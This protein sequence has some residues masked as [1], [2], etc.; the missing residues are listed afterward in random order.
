MKLPQ[1]TARVR[2]R[3]GLPRRCRESVGPGLLFAAALLAA[4][5]HAQPEPPI[6]DQADTEL[7]EQPPDQANVP[8]E[9]A[10][11]IQAGGAAGG[12][13]QTPPGAGMFDPDREYVGD[14]LSLNFQEIDTRAVLQLLAD[15]SRLNIVVSD[16]VQG[17]VTLRLQD[18]P[19]DQAL[20]IVLTTNG[21]DMRQNGNVIIVAPAEEIA[22]HDRSKTSSRCVRS[23][24]RSTTPAPMNSRR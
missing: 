13:P 8:P 21:L 1:A 2:R 19:W 10:A 14:R 16:T 6:S 23:C 15:T 17:S 12:Q 24:C 11:P 7:Q 18:V 20:D 3:A 4:A 9:P 22:A 5:A